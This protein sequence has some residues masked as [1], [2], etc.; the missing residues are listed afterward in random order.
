MAGKKPKAKTT[1]NKKPRA[2]RDSDIVYNA[3]RRYRRQAERYVKKAQKSTGLEKNRYYMLAASKYN[4]AMSTYKNPN[5]PRGSLAELAQ[6]FGT[7]FKA[8]KNVKGV[9]A[10]SVNE[11]ITHK[12]Q[13]KQMAQD[14][15]KM[16]G[17]GGRFYGGLSEI[18]TK[19][20]KSRKNPNKAILDFFGAKDLLE[21]MEILEK[22]GIDIYSAT[23][24]DDV[25][26][27]IQLQVQ[28]FVLEHRNNKD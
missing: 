25:Y 2:K 28:M 8:A 23:P 16:D 5:N 7:G 27:S 10:A 24:N 13:R 21:V 6:Y 19:D 1:A 18:W 22:E 17:V 3:R 9:V 20:E 15:L 4:A 12:N 14:L 11:L 26:V